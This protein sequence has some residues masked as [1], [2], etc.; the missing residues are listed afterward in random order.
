MDAPDTDA[1]ASVVARIPDFP[2]YGDEVARRRS[3]TLIRAYV[4]ESLALVRDRFAGSVDPALGERLEALLLHCQFTDQ[5]FVKHLEHA[6][7]E[8]P[9]AA[10]L[11][12]ADR[13]LVACADAMPALA[14][15]DLAMMI[16]RVDATF[17]RRKATIG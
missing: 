8:P 5:I 12:E 11:L 1:L 4:G 17:A 7:L 9:V 15:G 13:D 6:H 14:L 16:E 10:A 3:D 2:V